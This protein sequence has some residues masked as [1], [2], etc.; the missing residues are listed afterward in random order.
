MKLKQHIC[1]V[2]CSFLF[3]LFLS[4]LNAGAT[5]VSLSSYDDWANAIANGTINAVNAS[6]SALDYYSQTYGAVPVY[7][8]PSLLAL[9]NDASGFADNSLVMYWNDTA[10]N[11]VPQVA[12]WQY[13]LDGVTNF[14]QNLVSFKVYPTPGITDVSFTLTDANGNFASWFWGNLTTGEFTKIVIDPTIMG[15]QSGSNGFFSSTNFDPTSVLYMTFDERWNGRWLESP[16][17]LPTANVSWNAWSTLDV[18]KVPIPGALWLFGSGV[19]G[20]LFWHR[21]RLPA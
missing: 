20:L 12:A 14:A 8:M 3:F 21:K 2:I 1:A 15:R 13:N 5:T 10:L 7:T 6:Y 11:E 4:P 16:S 9:T 19:M 18:S 17:F